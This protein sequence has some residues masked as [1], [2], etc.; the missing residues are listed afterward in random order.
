[1]KNK[2]KLASV[3]LLWTMAVG[4]VCAKE[5]NK[6][7]DAIVAQDGT[8]D[9]TT[10]QKAIDKAPTNRKEPWK[11]FV[12]NGSY[13][14]MVTVPKEKPFIHL[15]GQ[16]KEYTLIHF[17]QNVGGKPEKEGEPFWN[18]S[19]HNPDL[20]I[21]KAQGCVVLVNASDFYSENIS[22]VNDF[23]VDFQSGPQ[24]LAMNTKGDRI[25]FKNCVFRS[26]QDTWM[27]ATDDACRHYVKNCWIEGAVDYF[28]GGGDALLEECTLYNVRSGSVIVAPCH[29]TAKYGY[30]FRECTVDGNKQAANGKQKLGRPWHNSPRAIFINTVMRI[31][32]AKEGWTDMGAIPAIFA[33]YNSVD[34]AGNVLDLSNR[35][36]VYKGRGDAPSEGSCRASITKEEADELTYDN[37]VKGTDG[38]NPREY[39]TELA[40][41]ESVQFEKG[42]LSW[43]EVEG[44]KGYVVTVSDKAYVTGQTSMRIHVSGTM[45]VRA[46]NEFGGL[47]LSLIHI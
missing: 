4:S 15:I 5:S 43:S 27:T 38:W 29:R 36:T 28:Y 17:C 12:K 8:G 47:G 16:D 35:K 25:A 24:A 19:V 2:L 14:E 45:S 7:F 21:Y 30:V 1:M 34:A 23:G 13:N 6:V 46:I 11:I 18:H 32:L 9:Y 40:S 37:L 39:M 41:P 31:P 22:Y 26:F 33:E 3:L 42:E 10:V 44:A 20:P